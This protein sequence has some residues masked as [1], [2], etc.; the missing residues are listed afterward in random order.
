[1]PGFADLFEL[2]REELCDFIIDNG[3]QTDPDDYSSFWKGSNKNRLDLLY[4]ICDELELSVPDWGE[5]H[6]LDRNDLEDVVEDL[7]LD[8]NVA[9]FDDDNDG[10]EELASSICEALGLEEPEEE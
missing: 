4:A 8:I 10:S 2:T 1:M 7:E 6:E 3:L 5:V 9:D